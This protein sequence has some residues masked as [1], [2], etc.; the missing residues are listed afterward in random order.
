MRLF[1]A[2]F[3]A[4]WGLIA[5]SAC[6]NDAPPA[7]APPEPASAS[8]P[9]A[10]PPMPRQAST[11]QAS[12]GRQAPDADQPLWQ[13]PKPVERINDKLI[14]R[15]SDK[16]AVYHWIGDDW[17]PLH[18]F[19]PRA[20]LLVDGWA[21]Q[22]NGVIWLHLDL[23]GDLDGWARLNESP[24]RPEEAQPLP[25]LAQPTLPTVQLTDADG[26]PH[27]ISLLGR[28]TDDLSI[29]VRFGDDDA[30]MWVDRWE[31]ENERNLPRLPVYT[32]VI[33]GRWEPWLRHEG[34]RL[35]IEVYP[36]DYTL[37]TWPNGPQ[38]PWRLPTDM[39]PVL[40]RSLDA[41]WLA[42]R[43][44]ALDPPVVWLPIGRRQLDFNPADLPIFLSAGL[45]LVTL[46]SDGR[47]ISS[48]FASQA[49]RN[50]EWRND[51]ELLLHGSGDG[52]WL[53]DVERNETRKLSDRWLSNVSPDGAFAVRHFQTETA[54]PD[55]Q[56]APSHIALVSLDDGREVIF[57]S[58]FKPWITEEP[59]FQQ[60]WSA[61]SQWLLSTVAQYYNEEQRTQYFALSRRGALVEIVPPEGKR[62]RHWNA[63]R[64]IETTGG[65]LRY[66][67]ADGEEIERPWSDEVFDPIA[68]PSFDGWE[69]ADDWSPSWS[70]GWSPDGRLLIGRRA[71]LAWEFD[72]DGLAALPWPNRRSWG[73]DEIGV[74][75]RNG[76]LLQVFRGFGL[77]CHQW[78][79]TVSWSP[80]GSRL[81]FGPRWTGCV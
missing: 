18:T 63:L 24:L 10:E 3:L 77:D 61:D 72:E 62:A 70:A 56:R 33:V 32:G 27:T 47:A 31:I 29:A 81:L 52:T 35:K 41:Q 49:W 67:N 69:L 66:L 51:Q 16:L 65:R 23:N 20:L 6:A 74:F 7:F 46:D 25:E 15:L 2:A 37:A 12:T 22:D 43:V 38:L 68:V 9:T 11:E 26:N 45:E 21:A 50:W 42:L 64:E 5:I 40:G 14:I 48:I 54:A 44:S 36:W 59:G 80:N 73:V 78:T 13:P 79:S 55:G 34:E 4:L 58:V 71:Q 60:Y 39:Y 30:V 8:Q 53:W 75:N 76:E 57:E 28:S 1:T 17:L 19:G